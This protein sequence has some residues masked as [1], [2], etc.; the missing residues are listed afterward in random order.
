MDKRTI[1][2]I[3]KVMVGI[4]GPPLRLHRLNYSEETDIESKRHHS[5]VLHGYVFSDGL[6]VV[7]STGP[8][9]RNSTS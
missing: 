1:N 4:L 5:N 3:T 6:G 7:N 9:I 8:I 2:G